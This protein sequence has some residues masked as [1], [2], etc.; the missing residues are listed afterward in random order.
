MELNMTPVEPLT[1]DSEDKLIAE[2]TK[3][4]LEIARAEVNKTEFFMSPKQKV[5]AWVVLLV[6]LLCN[7]SNQWQRFIISVAYFIPPRPDPDPFYEIRYAIP[8]F[9]LKKYSYLAGATFTV[10]FATAV[11]F[12][13]VLADNMSRKVLLCVAAI[14]WSLTSIGTAFCKTYWQLCL[15]RIFLGLFEACIGPPAYSLITDFFPPEKRT[16]ANSVYS[17]GIYIGASLSNLTIIIIE[18]IGWR[19]TYFIIGCF[20]IVIGLIGI[21]SIVEPQR[22]RYEP[23]KEEVKDDDDDDLPDP[24]SDEMPVRGN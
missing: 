1:D 16:L 11:L 24:T 15:M 9:S 12:T 2:L 3:K 13:G 23:K 17:F 21:V 8:D 14:L 19:M 6:I 20:G 10:F 4:D 7:I 5:Y 22:G 18:A